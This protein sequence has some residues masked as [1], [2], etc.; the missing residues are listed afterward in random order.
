MEF[1]NVEITTEEWEAF[2]PA[3]RERIKHLLRT[4]YGEE[5][6]QMLEDLDNGYCEDDE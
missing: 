6:M 4:Q 3:K 2:P 1:I 5:T